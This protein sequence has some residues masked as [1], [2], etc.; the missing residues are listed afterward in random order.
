MNSLV[1]YSKEEASNNLKFFMCRIKPNCRSKLLTII[2]VS[3]PDVAL[4]ITE[5][6]FSYFDFENSSNSITNAIGHLFMY[7]PDFLLG[8]VVSNPG[9]EG[10]KL[11]LHLP[12]TLLEVYSNYL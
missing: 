6:S 12:L 2:Y 9:A 3:E 10:T 1:L 7:A 11:F 5:L 8:C 4:S